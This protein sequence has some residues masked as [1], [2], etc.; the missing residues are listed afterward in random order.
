MRRPA[1][2]GAGLPLRGDE[3]E[4]VEGKASASK[5]EGEE[6]GEEKRGAGRPASRSNAG[7]GKS[8]RPSFSAVFPGR[9][10]ISPA[11]RHNKPGT[12]TSSARSYTC[13][14]LYVLLIELD[15]PNV[16]RDTI[17]GK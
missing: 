2:D 11:S 17:G 16:A 6:E 3:E 5:G 7:R 12:G 10:S 13:C 1:E 4:D 15:A 8:T 9:T 14:R